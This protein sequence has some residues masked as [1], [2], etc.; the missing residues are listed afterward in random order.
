MKFQGHKNARRIKIQAFQ[1]FG[2]Q[3]ALYCLS[4]TAIVQNGCLFSWG[5]SVESSGA[6]WKFGDP[7]FPTEFVGRWLDK[8]ATLVTKRCL[9]RRDTFKFLPVQS[10]FRGRLDEV[11][12]TFH[13]FNLHERFLH[14]VACW[15]HR[16]FKP[17]TTWVE[18]GMTAWEASTFAIPKHLKPKKC[19]E[20]KILVWHPWKSWQPSIL[21]WF[22]QQFC[23]L[24]PVLT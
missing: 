23:S 18:L 17:T 14:Y 13:E 22:H 6:Y 10:S 4:V 5:G 7:I 1:H 11:E 8:D 16:K 21:G 19:P 15:C 12:M 20:W 2:F 3:K 24:L 9:R